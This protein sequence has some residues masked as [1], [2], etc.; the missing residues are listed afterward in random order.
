M[1]YSEE[2]YWTNTDLKEEIYDS[3]SNTLTQEKEVFDLDV[4]R[5]RTELSGGKVKECYCGE[6]DL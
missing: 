6:D 3:S 4:T 2:L 5:D 1:A